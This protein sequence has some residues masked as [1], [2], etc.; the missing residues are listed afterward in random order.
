MNLRLSPVAVAAI[1]TS[2]RF[3]APSASHAVGV[4]GGVCA[5]NGSAEHAASAISSH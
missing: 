3:S 2:C 1:A 4:F 5:A